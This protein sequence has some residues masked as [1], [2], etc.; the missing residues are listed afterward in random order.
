MKILAVILLVYSYFRVYRLSQ[1]IIKNS[2]DIIKITIKHILWIVIGGVSM[3]FMN[4]K[5]DI[6]N[7]MEIFKGLAVVLTFTAFQSINL[8]R[9]ILNLRKNDSKQV[10]K[11]NLVRK[12]VI[13]S[14]ISIL[15]NL[16]AILMNLNIVI[17]FIICFLEGTY[18]VFFIIKSIKLFLFN[19]KN[20]K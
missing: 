12:V 15:V 17:I 19:K 13:I 14:L 4:S 11:E 9:G 3:A 2:K 18:I 20:N 1:E 10:I 5:S 6:P 8:V 7:Y 16:I